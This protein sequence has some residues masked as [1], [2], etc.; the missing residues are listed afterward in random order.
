M[1]FLSRPRFCVIWLRCSEFTL[2]RPC[3]RAG[4]SQPSVEAFKHLRVFQEMLNWQK[5]CGFFGTYGVNK[6]V[7]FDNFIYGPDAKT[8]KASW[9]QYTKGPTD[10]QK[11]QVNIV[12]T[13]S[14]KGYASWIVDSMTGQVSGTYQ[15]KF[16]ST[17]DLP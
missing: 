11:L 17:M 8:V 2:V 10:K 9:E 16:E 4:G 6:Q 5:Q 14:A 15:M 12:R 1:F 7:I 3:P 13:L